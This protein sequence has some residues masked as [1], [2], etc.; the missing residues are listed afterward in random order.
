M[1]FLRTMFGA[2]IPKAFAVT[3]DQVGSGPGIS[4]MWSKIQEVFPFSSEGASLPGTVFDKVNEV[5]L[6][7]IAG[8]A[9]AMLTYAG[10]RMMSSGG[11]EEGYN[12]AKKI[13]INVAIGLIAAMLADVV[14]VYAVS[15][16]TTVA[17]GTPS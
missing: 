16:L 15:L 17:G 9:V 14:I 5:I 2:L 11:G 12:Q 10:V 3:L 8:V 1:L 7:L 4:D 13:A 6:G